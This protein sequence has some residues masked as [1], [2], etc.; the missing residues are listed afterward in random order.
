MKK[1]LFYDQN[2][3]SACMLSLNLTFYLG[4]EVEH[5]SQD[6]DFLAEINSDKEYDL[7]IVKNQ[8]EQSDIINKSI[9]VLGKRKT[10]IPLIYFGEN[11]ESKENIYILK[12]C[13]EI[14]P[15]IKTSAQILGVTSK[16]MAELELPPYISI[17]SDIIHYLMYFPCETFKPDKD[18]ENKFVELFQNKAK[19]ENEEVIVFLEKSSHFYIKSKDRLKLANSLR[20][21]MAELS[22]KVSDKKSTPGEKLAFISKSLDIISNK[23]RHGKINE[24]VIDLAEK[25][26]ESSIE[27]VESVNDFSEL[28]A[29]LKDSVRLA[30]AHVLTYMCL[31]VL[32]N[33]DWWLEDEIKNMATASFFHDIYLE[34]D[35]QVLVSTEEELA[36]Y[37]G[38]AEEKEK[39]NSHAKTVSENIIKLNNVTSETVTILKEHHGSKDGVGFS[40]NLDGLHNLSKVF[41]V[42]EE[43]VHEILRNSSNNFDQV[44]LEE[45]LK[46]VFPDPDV[47]D[48]IHALSKVEV[49]DMI[50]SVFKDVI[51]T[52][53]QDIKIKAEQNKDEKM[54]F[55][56]IIK[57][58]VGD[59][60]TDIFRFAGENADLFK[61]SGDPSVIKNIT[62]KMNEAKVIVKG[63]IKEDGSLD[64]TV[65]SSVTQIVNDVTQIVKEKLPEELP[66]V[67]KIKDDQGR[68]KLMIAALT[69][70]T[71]MVEMLAQD[72]SILQLKDKM[73][74]NVLH[75]G[76]MSGNIDVI[77]RCLNMRINVNSLD[78]KRRTPLFFSIYKDQTD[79][80]LHLIDKG[81]WANVKFENNMTLPILAAHKGNE[82]V[83]VELI[84]NKA[85]LKARDFKGRS[86]FH[87]AR[88][89]G[90]R[91]ILEILKKHGLSS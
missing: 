49:A 46:K 71:M 7:I 90:H 76:A 60:K 57:G 13:D 25:S 26:I 80:A 23:F 87:Y 55:F 42:T 89:G 91:N 81:S 24:E 84:Q 85:P 77:D 53:K 78:T 30:H 38:E 18:E 4:R 44:E 73:G 50:N 64:K 72:K 54:D 29:L 65:I 12:F 36:S 66:K 21:Q 8:H 45:R 27:L 20:K 28:M 2:P 5:F 33:I 35:K 59:T 9:E 19:T 15:L 83:L 74:M 47:K 69:G 39:I 75:Y 68:T 6:Q 52:E 22:E 86:A 56:Q 67:A 40:K 37:E 79:A 62:D 10:F 3:E 48:V 51:A 88:T 14:R 32:K 16:Q 82:K 11:E 61:D 43:W 31:N 17:P 63:N 41:I 34:S 1:I 70:N 58:N